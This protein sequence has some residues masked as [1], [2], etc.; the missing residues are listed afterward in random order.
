[1]AVALFIENEIINKARENN[2]TGVI[3]TNTS[4]MEEHIRENIYGFKKLCD[5]PANK[6]ISQKGE[7]P[8]INAPD[9]LRG[10]IYYHDVKEND[11]N[12]ESQ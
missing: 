7:K 9:N 12:S 11:E 3:S 6:F 4:L 2:F 10:S 1:M 8:F 5:Y